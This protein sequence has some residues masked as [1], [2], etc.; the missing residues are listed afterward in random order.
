MQAPLPPSAF[1]GQ[2]MSFHPQDSDWIIWMG[3]TGDCG[4]FTSDCH[5]EAFY[6]TDNGH[7]W[8]KIETYVKS[9]GWARD[10]DLKIDRR[11]ILCESYRDKRGN[12]RL[13]GPQYPL[14]LWEGTDFYKNKVKLFDNVVGFTKFSEYLIVAEVSVCPL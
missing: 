8:N 9:C 2:I 5:A 14:E 3:G 6:T 13:F 4:S 10:T 7:N 11:L 12:Q 1:G